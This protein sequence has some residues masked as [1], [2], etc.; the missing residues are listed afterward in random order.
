MPAWEMIMDT[1]K[2]M[3]NGLY[4]FGSAF[5]EGFL[6]TAAYSGPSPI[7]YADDVAAAMARKYRG[8]NS[9]DNDNNE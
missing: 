9:D 5:G 2:A 6:S 3:G 4:N 1:N 8:E 7:M